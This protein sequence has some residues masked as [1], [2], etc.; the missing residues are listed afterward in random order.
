M[1]KEWHLIEKILTGEKTLEER[2]Y[3]FKRPPYGA[4]KAGDT[5]YFKDSGKPVSV[6]AQVTKVLQFENLTPEKSQEIVKKHAHADLGGKEI[7]KEI[8]EYTSNKNYCVVIFFKNPK[9]VKPFEINK[10]GFGLMAAWITV[11]NINKVKI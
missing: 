4:I 9:K 3:K 2:W 6:K 8:K 7:T 11:G 5:I 1:K 10:K